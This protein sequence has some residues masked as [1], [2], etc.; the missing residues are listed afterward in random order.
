M[1]NMSLNCL[2]RRLSRPLRPRRR[3]S[4][5]SQRFDLSKI[6]H[7]KPSGSAT[8]NGETACFAFTSLGRWIGRNPP[9]D[10]LLAAMNG[11]LR[12]NIQ[13]LR[14]DTLAAEDK[15]QLMSTKAKADAKTNAGIIAELHETI[16]GLQQDKAQYLLLGQA[17]AVA[18]I[19]DENVAE[20]ASTVMAAG[21][22]AVVGSF[23]E[24]PV[25]PSKTKAT[26]QMTGTAEQS[27]HQAPA[28]VSVLSS[29]DCGSATPPRAS[30]FGP[31]PCCAVSSVADVG[32]TIGL[33]LDMD[34]D[35]L[36]PDSPWPPT[37]PRVS[38]SV[39]GPIA[40]VTAQ[41]AILS[42][43][44]EVPAAVVVTPPLSMVASPVVQITSSAKAH[45]PLPEANA[46]PDITKAFKETKHRV[47]CQCPRRPMAS[48]MITAVNRINNRIHGTNFLVGVSSF[49]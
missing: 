44:V 28:V 34:G 21:S 4:C 12:E 5:S 24:V 26:V 42:D 13:D 36:P 25:S 41:E 19:T 29:E 32:P 10:A 27:L 40:V 3:F 8:K 11:E 35:L 22:V 37:P 47:S 38:D 39:I 14:Q 18:K 15:A 9:A 43:V 30:A 48:S 20:S 33:D 31:H 6:Y 1:S 16:K 46:T 17:T 49:L 23:S 2:R 7:V 45:V